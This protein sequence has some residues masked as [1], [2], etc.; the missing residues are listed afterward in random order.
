MV[1]K[2]K[3]FDKG[4]GYKEN[5]AIGKRPEQGKRQKDFSEKT[6]RACLAGGAQ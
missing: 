3:G 6:G 4:R 2:G 5:G 1:A